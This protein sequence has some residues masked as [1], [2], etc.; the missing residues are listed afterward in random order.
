MRT[1]L[2]P[3]TPA[4]DG[5]DTTSMDSR[6]AAEN[7]LLSLFCCMLVAIGLSRVHCRRIDSVRS[8]GLAEE[9]GPKTLPSIQPK[10]FPL[11]SRN[12]PEVRENRRRKCGK[13]RK[14]A[15]RNGIP[16]Q[17]SSSVSGIANS[18]SHRE[19]YATHPELTRSRGVGSCRGTDAD[20]GSPR[21]PVN[22]ARWTARI[23][24]RTE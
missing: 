13:P 23:I 10:W 22:D 3:Q 1:A 7:A 17:T 19:P 18:R 5:M 9:D 20:L 14:T 8:P 6:V 16:I 11:R 2:D 15:G 24:A 4:S 12:L 21:E